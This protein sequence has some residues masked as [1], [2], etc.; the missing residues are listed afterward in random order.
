MI[1]IRKIKDCIAHYNEQFFIFAH[2]HA[3]EWVILRLNNDA[4]SY[5][6]PELGLRCPELLRVAANY[7]RGVLAFLLFE[8]LVLTHQY[9]VI[10]YSGAFYLQRHNL[11]RLSG[12]RVSPLARDPEGCRLVTL[13]SGTWFEHRRIRHMAALNTNQN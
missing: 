9:R 12:D 2:E 4:R 5:P 1:W 6:L 13:K 3:S 8:L 11:E 10:N 7:Q